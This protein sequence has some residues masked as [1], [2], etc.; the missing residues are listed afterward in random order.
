MAELIKGKA[1]I[2]IVN[3][4]TPEFIKLCLRSIRK[5]T[6]YP[7]EVIVVDNNSQDKSL[8]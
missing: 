6:K 1:M 8:E 7:Y 3:Y 2:C 4:K 5:F